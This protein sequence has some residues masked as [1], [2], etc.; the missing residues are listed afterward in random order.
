M[1]V[2]KVELGFRYA[3][4]SFDTCT[5]GFGLLGQ[6]VECLV[7]AQRRTLHGHKAEGKSKKRLGNSLFISKL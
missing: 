3:V 1:N 6:L 5:N 4:R 7:D 2:A